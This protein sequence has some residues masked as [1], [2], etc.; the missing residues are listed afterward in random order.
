MVFRGCST[1]SRP[2]KD[3]AWAEFPTKTEFDAFRLCLTDYSSLVKWRRMSLPHEVQV[4]AY[5]ATKYRAEPDAMGGLHDAVV[6]MILSGSWTI[7]RSGLDRL[8]IETMIGLLTR[9]CRLSDPYR[10]SVSAA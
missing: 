5:I 6:G 4:I 9:S 10:S 8:V 7:S 1:P 2:A 3:S